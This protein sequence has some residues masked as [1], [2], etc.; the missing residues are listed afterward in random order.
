MADLRLY[1]AATIV[2]I[3]LPDPVSTVGDYLTSAPT[4]V[5]GDVTISKDGGT[6]FGAKNDATVPE[7]VTDGWAK[8]TLNGTDLTAAKIA[9]KLVDLSGSKEWVDNGWILET[10]GNPSAEHEVFPADLKQ[11]LST[12]LTETTPGN[13][14][15]NFKTLFDNN[16]VLTTRL[17]DDIGNMSRILNTL[18]VESSGGRIAGNVDFFFNNTDLQTV[19]VV[20]D[21]GGGAILAPVSIVANSQTLI[22]GTI[23]SGGF[24]DTQAKDQVSVKVDVAAGI[25]EY[26]LNFNVGA[27]TLFQDMEVSIRVNTTGNR[28]MVIELFNINTVVF[29][30]FKVVNNTAGIY[31]TQF[32]TSLAADYTAA[33]GDVV[34]NFLSVDMQN[35]QSI[36][37]DFARVVFEGESGSIPTAIENAVATEALLSALHGTA[38]WNGIDI[39]ESTV[40]SVT[41]P[42]VIVLTSGNESANDLYKGSFYL[43]TDS[44]DD[45]LKGASLITGY[46]ASTRTVT[47]ANAVGFTQIPGDFV[48]IIGNPPANL[49]AILDTVISETT[50]G[51][52]ANNQSLFW[53]NNDNQ[54]TAVVDDIKA[55]AGGGTENFVANGEIVTNGTVDTGTFVSTQVADGTYF[56]L[57]PNG[58]PLDVSLTFNIGDFKP[59]SVSIQGRMDTDAGTPFTEIY[60]FDFVGSQLELISSPST[61]MNETGVDQV[62]PFFLLG[63]HRD[64]NGD[65]R[66]R[67]LSSDG[68]ATRNLFLDQV[69]VQ[70]TSGLTEAGIAAA[71]FLA[72]SSIIYGGTVFIDTI[73]G[74]AG[75]TIGIN[76]IKSNPV[77]SLVDAITIANAEGFKTFSLFAGSSIVLSQMFDGFLFLGAV[78]TLALNGQNINGCIFQGMIISGIGT[79]SSLPISIKRCEIGTATLPTFIALECNLSGTITLD[80]S[81]GVDFQLRNCATGIPGS[82][83]P[84]IVMDTGVQLDINSYS[85]GIEIHGMD[86]TN[87]VTMEG[88]GRVVLDASCTGGLI[89]ISGDISLV[90]NTSGAVTIDSDSRNARDT[91]TQDVVDGLTV[92]GASKTGDDMGIDDTAANTTK[93]VD[94]MAVMQ[95]DGINFQD[96]MVEQRSMING[97]FS[98]NKT[99]GITTYFKKDGTT[100]S[101]QIKTELL[102]DLITTERTRLSS[103]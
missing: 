51:R 22:S 7:Y 38:L 62:Y 23:A 1:G 86:A 97:K 29:D 80:S 19:K 72:F 64:T 11:I 17:L 21:V 59:S 85:G 46:T 91:I 60:A 99:T 47:L 10:Y 39:I 49:H 25:M 16:N 18:L 3:P 14:G 96:V 45:T 36:E 65:V 37:I 67:F 89:N 54:T 15:S 69:I 2:M 42:T 68:T 48:R 27:G 92:Y 32:V 102:L 70:G 90:D 100:Q 101:F 43:V 74:T 34:M 79:I 78:S 52:I 33:N 57:S 35:G 12:A 94:S 30:T 5:I 98:F 88:N 75:I 28:S 4:F 76:G 9:I 87:S 61:R 83:D 71:T 20:N 103:P 24:A 55:A 77:A 66:I 53:D 63:R 41:S 13:I 40:E 44:A 50:L 84:V 93:I 26:R 31:E 6:T 73:N 81:T 8:I 58:S 56:Q 82:A 95:V